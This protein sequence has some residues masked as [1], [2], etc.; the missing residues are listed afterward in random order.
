MADSRGTA[1][2]KVRLKKKTNNPASFLMREQMGLVMPSAVCVEQRYPGLQGTETAAWGVPASAWAAATAE[3]TLLAP[4][5]LSCLWAA[6][7]VPQP[8]GNGHET[9][10][11]SG[12]TAAASL[13]LAHQ[14]QPLAERQLSSTRE[15]MYLA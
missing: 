3:G 14:R 5:K 6:L 10:E 9:L 7:G 4:G 15:I 12:G 1:V 2:Q 13:L 11:M 8:G